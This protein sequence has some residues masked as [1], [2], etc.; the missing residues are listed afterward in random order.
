MYHCR[1]KCFLN[2]FLFLLLSYTVQAQRDIVTIGGNARSETGSVSYS[3]GQTTYGSFSGGNQQINQGVQQVY[4]VESALG[5]DGQAVNPVSIQVYPNPSQD[6]LFIASDFASP[7]RFS[8]SDINGKLILEGDLIKGVQKF[9]ME[10]Y[11]PASYLLK[12]TDQSTFI[13][14]YQLI[15]N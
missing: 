2:F 7:L 10:S 15:K 5:M 12:I 13:Q 3:I 14:S 4:Q 11:A 6:W 8:L 1:M 9:S